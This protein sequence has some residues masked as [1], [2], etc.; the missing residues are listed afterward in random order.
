M[1]NSF[2][3]QLLP[4]DFI[5]HLARD[6]PTGFREDALSSAEIPSQHV[7]IKRHTKARFRLALCSIVSA[8]A[9]LTAA[10]QLESRSPCRKT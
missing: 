9:P 4:P 2:P 10:A 5:F 1:G 6:L 3:T 8:L 7:G